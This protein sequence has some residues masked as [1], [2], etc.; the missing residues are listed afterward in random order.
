MRLAPPPAS[1]APLLA[2]V[3]AGALRGQGGPDFVRE[4]RP[5]LSRHCF[6]CHGPDAE[7]READLR[8]DWPAAGAAGLP[9]EL[10][11]EIV[12][13]IGA[14]ADDPDRM[15][16]RSAGAPLAA[17]Q[18]ATLRRWLAA[19]G[20]YAR[21][22]AFV[23]P[24]RPPLP[25][26]RSGAPHPIDR[27]V[28]ARLEA[29][30]LRPAPE[31]DRVTLLRRAYG[32]L[33]GLVPT[34]AETRQFVEDPRPDAWE[35]LV[36]R[37]LDSP[38]Y[39]ERMASRWLDLARYADTNGYEKDRPRSIW[40]YRD[41]VIRAFDRDDGFD[42][43]VVEQLAGDM[44]PDAT[45]EQIL[46]SGFHR[47]TMLN[48]EGGIDPLE[49]RYLAV[50]DRVNTTG[51][52]V[53]GLTVGCAQCHTH[54]FDPLTQ[55]EYYGLFAFL[56]Q[57]DEPP[58]EVPGELVPEHARRT[59]TERTELA[60]AERELRSSWPADAEP[61]EGRFLGWLDEQRDARVD[62][63]PLRLVEATSNLPRLDP[64]DDGSVLASG[65]TTKHDT[66]R[67][68]LRA[69]ELPLR[70]LRIEALP[71]PR[72][73]D[74]GPGLTYYEGTHGDFFLHELRIEH[75][76]AAVAIARATVSYA[77]NRF[78][79]GAVGG[80]EM[81]DG[82]PQ[83]GWSV[84]GRIGER[85]TAV[86]ELAEP[87]PA[88]GEFVLQ[89]DFGRHF[90]SSLGRFRLS[91]TSAPGPLQAEAYPPDVDRSLGRD[92][93]DLSPAE[94]DRLRTAF[95]MQ[96]PEVRKAADRVRELRRGPA[97]VTSLVMQERS[98]DHRRVTHRHHRGDFLQPRE[99]VEPHTPAFLHAWPEELPRDRLGLARWLTARDNPLFARVA[100]NRQ[101]AM[102]FGTG[103]VRTLED[104]GTQGE[105]PSH[106]ELLDWLAVEFMARDFSLK[107]LHRL[108][109]T[110]ATWRQ[111]AT[112]DPAAREIDPENRLLAYAPRF[113]RDAEFVRDSALRAAGVLDTTRFGPPVRPPQPD[114]V[115]EIAF[116]SP[117]WQAGSGADRLRR[118]IYTFHKRTAPY[119]LLHV[120][121][122]PSREHCTARRDRSNTAL[123]ALALLNDPQ[124][125]EIA[126]HFGR[127]L[128]TCEA[129]L[130]SVDAT[131]REAFVRALTREPDESELQAMRE[132]LAAQQPRFAA[133]PAAARATIGVAA[134]AAVEPDQLARRAAWTALARA[135]FAL[136][137]FVTRN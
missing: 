82:D 47:N 127:A 85:H 24:Q 87:L 1:I 34:P 48:E 94:L 16:P 120:F 4:V 71:D 92:A 123:Q 70:A 23:P 22:W 2:L 57:A 135:L 5:L 76:D 17:P 78:G 74:G 101:W 37:L 12:R 133:D 137:E 29:H 81:V 69:G 130:G 83:T 66:Y 20:V 112:V 115:T 58:Y 3:V 103:L 42:R 121:D 79:R 77:A 11:D 68:R 126:Q 9:Q 118:S 54:K 39:G 62:W 64:Q 28:H 91:G 136:D 72:L 61:L 40:P 59:P 56:D 33:L 111:S 51:T 93:A 86:I 129:E 84:H 119:A 97:P 41:E 44:L 32:D 75:G 27:F 52:A 98:A 13:R 60:A 25:E 65:D 45:P 128:A 49:F 95:L 113:R 31:A 124:M 89:L 102:L 35:R 109:L 122:V 10:R 50:V 90:A 67:L 88:D 36:D 99:V 80:A 43:F 106:P 63:R 38:H 26:C 55:R 100:V 131:L 116:G 132:F 18:I 6:P 21:H 7:T 105:A 96:A 134:D 73:P 46:A 117:H 104:F 125:V 8:L 107:E 53:L 110:S 15:P 14:P 19:G 30:G 114:G 108:I